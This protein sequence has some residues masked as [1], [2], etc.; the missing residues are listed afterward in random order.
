MNGLL[1]EGESQACEEKN[2]SLGGVG[3]QTRNASKQEQARMD[4][5]KPL[6][7]NV[8]IKYKNGAPFFG[9]TKTFSNQPITEIEA[10]R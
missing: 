9:A 2:N 8:E 3:S 5:G 10:S 4:I 6:D 7:F 1:E